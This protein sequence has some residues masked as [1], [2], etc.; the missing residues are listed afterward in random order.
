MMN[1][2]YNFL[3]IP[4]FDLQDLIKESKDLKKRQFA[5][6]ASQLAFN[7]MLLKED[8]VGD[9]ISFNGNFLGVSND[10]RTHFVTLLEDIHMIKNYREETLYSA[11]S[12][13]D[14]YLV[15][16]AVR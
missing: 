5:P 1:R 16:L 10:S 15:N 13:A 8:T 12:I 4:S 7:D 9:Y 14:R 2:Y 11:V 3:I 6:W